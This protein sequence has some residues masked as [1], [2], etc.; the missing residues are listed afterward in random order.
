M[1]LEQIRSI[2]VARF[3]AKQEWCLKSARMA[4]PC[5][6]LNVTDL[7]NKQIAIKQILMLGPP[8]V[9]HLPNL[10]QTY[11]CVPLACVILQ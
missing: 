7:G 4:G 1:Q 10:T 5:V 8:L 3:V 6:G 11:Q 9:I 2:S